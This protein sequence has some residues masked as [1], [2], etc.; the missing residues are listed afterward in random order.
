MIHSKTS[1][2]SNRFKRS[3]KKLCEGSS[4]QYYVLLLHPPHD[5]PE[6]LDQ[7]LEMIQGPKK[8]DYTF[9]TYTDF[10]KDIS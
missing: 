1:R 7:Q 10:I 6:A 8:A 9:K 2:Q 5:P 3:T 4:L